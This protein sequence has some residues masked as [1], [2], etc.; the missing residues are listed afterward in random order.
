MKNVRIHNVKFDKTEKR[1]NKKRGWLIA[2]VRQPSLKKNS[3]D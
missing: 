1:G 3:K 2:A